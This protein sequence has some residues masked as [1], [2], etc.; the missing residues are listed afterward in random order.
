MKW[1]GISG[2]IGSGK[3]LA[4]Q[5]FAQHYAIPTLNADTIARQLTAPNG[6]ALPT[7][8]QTFGHSV[9]T[10]Q[11]QLDRA[12]LRQLVFRQPEALLALEA[13]LHPLIIQELRHRQT[14]ISNAP[15][16]IIE[17]PLLIERPI[18]QQLISRIII[19][20][21]PLAIQIRR[22]KHRS[23]LTHKQI[24]AIINT[25]ASRRQRHAAAH[26]ILHN[27]ST[28]RTLARQIQYL[29]QGYLKHFSQI[30]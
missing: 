10:S 18:F 20:D 17:I 7:I 4:T 14:H 15:Y 11:N 21:C 6:I 26:D 16:G 22:V 23:G 19:I 12:A 3:S 27:H 13:I 24:L 1:V 8:H 30:P 29:H 5:F 25:Q 2:G 9:F 28:P